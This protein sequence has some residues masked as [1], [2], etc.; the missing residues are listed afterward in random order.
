[1]KKIIEWIILILLGVLTLFETL[2]LCLG[3]FGTDFTQGGPEPH[4]LQFGWLVL[5]CK[6]V[7]LGISRRTGLLMLAAGLFNWLYSV[8]F[9]QMQAQHQSFGV[10]LSKSPLDGAYLI[11]ALL[12][13]VVSGR[14]WVTTTA[15][16]GSAAM[17]QH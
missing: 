14:W 8:V 6:I 5:I 16:S 17:S 13:I 11:L 3:Q 7:G 2:I 9:I 10:A 15:S 12:Y 4:G 1:M